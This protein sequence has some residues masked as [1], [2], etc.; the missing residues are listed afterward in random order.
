MNIN[1]MR[2]AKLQKQKLYV[3][4]WIIPYYS[5]FEDTAK[6]FAWSLG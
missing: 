3:V 6:S 4:Q 1:A 5:Y 2:D